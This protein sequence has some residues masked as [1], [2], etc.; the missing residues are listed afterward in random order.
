[1]TQINKELSSE[2]RKELFRILKDRFETN[3]N[4]HTEMEWSKVQQRLEAHTEKLWSLHEMDRTGGEPDVVGYDTEQD[5]YIFYDCSAESPKG[6]RAVCYDREAL[7]SR[8]KHNSIGSFLIPLISQSSS[9]LLKNRFTFLTII[10]NVIKR[11]L[12]SLLF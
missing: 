7:E 9:E 10:M 4:R 2:Q 6:R 3:M 12:A 8:K 1:M 11:L 5:E